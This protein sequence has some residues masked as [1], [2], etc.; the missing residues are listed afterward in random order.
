MCGEGGTGAH[1]SLEVTARLPTVAYLSFVST[2]HD[3][4]EIRHGV[5]DRDGAKGS[6]R[7]SSDVGNKLKERQRE[8]EGAQSIEPQEREHLLVINHHRQLTGTRTENVRWFWKERKLLSWSCCHDNG[9]TGR[10]G[11]GK[12]AE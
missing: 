2:V 3:V 6:R 11:G 4:R 8:N 7:Q 10:G 9:P 12:D 1:Q 5:P